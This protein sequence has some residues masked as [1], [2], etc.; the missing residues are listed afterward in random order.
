MIDERWL[1]HQLI[2]RGLITQTQFDAAM[3]GESELSLGLIAAGAIQEHDL[4]RFLG[5]QF[6]TRYVTTEKLS[7][8]KV[9]QW[10]LD[11]LP[12]D[13][14]ERYNVVPVRCD[15]Q[16]GGVLSI[17]TPDPTDQQL[18]EVVQ[19]TSMARK[20]D[21]YVSL[22]HAVDAALR[23]WYKGD[24]HAFA[25]VDQL[26]NSG[27]PQMLDIYDQRLI[28]FGGAP[29]ADLPDEQGD[30][31]LELVTD[32]QQMMDPRGNLREAAPKSPPQSR[33][34]RPTAPLSPVSAQGAAPLGDEEVTPPPMDPRDPFADPH[35]PPPPSRAP[36]PSQARNPSQ[37]HL[38]QAHDPFTSP[39]APTPPAPRAESRAPDSS[40][41]PSASGPFSAAPTGPLPNS[42]GR[43]TGPQQLE[44]LVDEAKQSDAPDPQDVS[45][46]QESY[47]QTTSVLVNLLEMGQGWRQGH[48][49]EVARLVQL[50]ADRVGLGPQDIWELR[51][52]A[53]MHELG[54]P[55]EPHLTMLTM[56]GN[57]ELRALARR[58]HLTPSKLLESAHLPPKVT[59]LLGALYERADGE[60]IPGKLSGRDVPLGARLLQ[61]VDAFAD[62]VQNPRAPG[63]RTADQKAALERLREASKRGVLDENAVDIFYQVTTGDEMRDQLIGDRPRV[64]VIDSDAESTTVLELKLVAAGY[65]VRVVKTTAEAAREVLAGRL[66]LI[67]SEVVLKPVD[68]FGFLQRIRADGRTKNVPLI[69]VSERSDANDVNRGFELGAVDYIVKPYNPELLL[70]K[71]RMALA[72]K[73]A[74]AADKRGVSGSLQEMSLP[75]ILQILSAGQKTGKLRVRFADR[76]GE[77]FLDRG[78]VVQATYGDQRGEQ[79]FYAMLP[80]GEG[81]FDLD[82]NAAVPER[83]IHMS[84]EGLMLE[85]MRRYDE[86]SRD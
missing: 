85:A 8:A 1:G 35:Q 9:P 72:K 71:V 16:Q 77:I 33:P 32:P 86:I 19:R 49:T 79:A 17:V 46:H 2:E 11:L 65:D 23:K 59:Q 39:P 6:R 78:Q 69:F 82:P 67:L 61:V 4:L 40:P 12:A 70:A 62:L 27:Y 21:S 28:D 15:K 51:V 68:G 22:R 41:S 52:A 58:V 31:P 13:I 36:E 64:M 47:L 3:K 81:Q 48:S 37:A 38:S 44:E 73:P 43:P 74:Q 10:V 55:A 34:D 57:N 60:G 54:K 83:A 18:L 63:G 7:Q 53:L 20:V 76:T 30:E 50:L 14:C 26:L 84:T 29:I 56:D 66:D 80:Q 42:G 5:L 45:R 75:D 24:I 25:R